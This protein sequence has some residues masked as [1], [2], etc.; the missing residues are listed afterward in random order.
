[1][2]LVNKSFVSVGGEPAVNQYTLQ[3]E[4]RAFANAEAY[5]AGKEHLEAMPIAIAYDPSQ[6]LLSSC[7][8]HLKSLPEL[9]N[10]ADC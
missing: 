4:A 5:K 6:P 8:D 10:A 9:E 1:M 3:F 2:L 7:Y